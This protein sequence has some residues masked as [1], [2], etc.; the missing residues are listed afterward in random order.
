MGAFSAWV[1]LG[2]GCVLLCFYFSKH[3]ENSTVSGMVSLDICVKSV[4]SN[5]EMSRSSWIHMFGSFWH[6][7]D[8]VDPWLAWHPNN[9]CYNQNFSF[10]LWLKSWVTTQMLVEATKG[11]TQGSKSWSTELDVVERLLLVWINER[12]MASESIICKK[13]KARAINPVKDKTSTNASW[14]FPLFVMGTTVLIYDQLDL[15]PALASELSL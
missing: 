4:T 14:V 11:V 3:L 2:W 7:F 8:T 12:Q 6:I 9:L 13:K 5:I 10:D 1:D 15:W